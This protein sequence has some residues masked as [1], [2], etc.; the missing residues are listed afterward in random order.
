MVGFMA[1][2]GIAVDPVHVAVWALPT[3]L[4][5]FAIQAARLLL[6]ERRLKRKAA[7]S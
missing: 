6:F 4:A 2:S 5:A 3:A 7:R 1:S